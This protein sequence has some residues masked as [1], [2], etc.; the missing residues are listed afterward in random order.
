MNDLQVFK[1]EEFGNVRVVEIDGEPWFVGK[2][3]AE[4]LG[5]SDINKAVAMHVDDDDK[6]LNDKT[7]SSFG[8]RGANLIN[9]SGL[10]SLVL[11]SKLSTAKKFKRW[12]TSEVL[13]SIRKHGLYAIDE[14]VANPDLLF[15][16]VKAY[17]EE[18]EKTKKLQERNDI[19]EIE[20]KQ[21]QEVIKEL[22]PKADYTDIILKHPGLITI[23]QIA[24][25]YG[26]SAREMND[27]LHEM[28]IQYKQN[29][30]RVLYAKYANNGYVHSETSTFDDKRGF[31]HTKMWTKWT[32]KGRLFIYNK[33]KEKGIIPLIEQ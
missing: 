1:H 28:N 4:A 14:L 23:T 5:Y 11:S 33:L 6:K 17:R 9:E 10:Y 2:D 25:D 26:M 8:Q 19:L 7:S 18:R 13:P 30:Q 3:V 27:L 20:T 16:T 31:Y 22:K 29:G 24:K 21:Q 12:V 32:Q 15:E